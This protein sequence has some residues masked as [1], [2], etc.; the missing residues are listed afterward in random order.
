ML[1][2]VRHAH[3]RRGARAQPQHRLH[4]RLP[5][6]S[7]CPAG[8]TS[9][10]SS[11]RRRSTRSG[12]P[13]TSAD[14]PIDR[15]VRPHVPGR[16]ALPAAGRRPTT[17]DDSDEEPRP[18][19]GDL[20][21]GRRAG[22]RGRRRHP[23]LPLRRAG[24]PRHRRRAEPART[25]ATP[26]SSRCTPGSPPPSS[27]GS[28]QPHTGRRVVLAT[29]VAET[30]LTV[31]GIRY[32]VDPGTARISR[33]SHRLKVQRL[34][35]EPVSQASANQRKGR[36]GRTADGICIRL[37]AEEDFD[38]P[39]GVHR[40]GDPAHQPGLGH[41]ADDRARASATSPA[42]PFVDPPDRR[43][44]TDG[45]DAAAG[46]RRARRRAAGS[47]PLGRQLA[48]LPV[49]PRLARMV[50]EADRQ[51]LRRAR[52]WSSPPRC[53]SRTRAS[54]RPDKQQAGRRRSTPGS[55]TRTRTSSRYLN[56]WR[57][58]Q[59]AAEGA[60]R[61]ASSAGCAA[62]EFLQLPAGARVAGPLR[63]SCARSPGRSGVTLERPRRRRRR[64]ASTPALL[65]G[66]L[67]HIGLKDTG[68]ARVPRRA[69]RPVRDLPR[70]GAVQEAAALGDGR[71]AGRDVPAVGP[72]RRPDRAGVG[73]AAGRAPGQAQLQRA[74]LG[75]E[76]GRGDGVREGHALRRADRR[77][78]ARSNY[79]RIDP[80]LS[81]ELFIR[82]ALVEGDWDTHHAFFARQPAR[83]SPRSRSWS[84]GP[85][86][87]TSSSTTRPCSTSTTQRIPADVVSG[88]H[89]DAWWKKARRDR[90]RTCSP[91]TR[92]CW[93]TRAAD[94]VD[95]RRLPGRLAARASCGCR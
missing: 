39:A 60:V 87:A 12:S 74:A 62:A 33:Y 43:N 64:P 19:P 35:I 21:R 95:A 22:R 59:R 31:P 79:G 57:Y 42:F 92:R 83:C 86:A 18:D 36:C 89:F 24:D 84:T 56:L 61:P 5:A 13:G 55:P 48:Q 6:S 85:G 16:G 75:E 47:P 4:P 7:C 52:C 69:R 70:L 11:P 72:G 90:A 1:R 26:R 10:S 53:P 71:R 58:L 9:R 37:Y 94:A 25:C 46:A 2:A 3:H 15:G 49:D 45:V 63:A 38:G 73:R 28:S 50:L 78:R 23:G 80:E 27:T 66:L 82:H 68:Q 81:R 34:P 17:T 77:R 30:S 14:A 20:R 54:G 91:S 29:N 65:A 41:P 51:R 88:R 93:S 8:P 40:A 32:V 76:A 67:S 44:V